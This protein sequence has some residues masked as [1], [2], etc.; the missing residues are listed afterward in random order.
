MLEKITK[1]YKASW[2]YKIENDILGGKILVVF[3]LS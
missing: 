1:G 3:T 2:E